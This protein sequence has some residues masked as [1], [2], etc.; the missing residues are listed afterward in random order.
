Y[1]RLGAVLVGGPP[2][3]TR[4]KVIS[5]AQKA[6]E[7]DPELAEAHARLADIDQQ[8]FRWSDAEAEYKRALELR[9]NDAATHR[10]Y[11]LWLACQGR[12][13]EAV[14]WSR[15]AR[16]LDPLGTSGSTLGFILFYARHYDEAMLELRSVLAIRS[17]DAEALWYLGFV[18][19]AKGKPDE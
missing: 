1:R 19:I 18:L 13:E 6:L 4:S 10:A 14:A 7:I 16:E 17:D 15:R 9:P 11:A 5:A 3:E 12:M 2:A 8:L